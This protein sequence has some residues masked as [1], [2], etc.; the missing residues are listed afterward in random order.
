[1]AGIAYKEELL[2]FGTVETTLMNYSDDLPGLGALDWAQSFYLENSLLLCKV[3]S[4]IIIL[5]QLF[6]CTG[7][8]TT[9]IALSI[10]NS[11]KLQIV[12]P[13]PAVP[14]LCLTCDQDF[15]SLFIAT[16][17]EK[18]FKFTFFQGYGFSSDKH[19]KEMGGYMLDGVFPKCFSLLR[20]GVDDCDV[21]IGLS[22]GGIC[23]VSLPGISNS[24][25]QVPS[26]IVVIG[27][28]TSIL[29]T[30]TQFV[31]KR[32]SQET[33]LRVASMK[34]SLVVSLLSSGVLR[35]YSSLRPEMLSECDLATGELE[36]FKF[37]VLTD[38]HFKVVVVGYKENTTWWICMVRVFP[39]SFEVMGKFTDLGD[40]KG[41][42]ASQQGLWT[43]WDDQGLSKISLTSFNAEATQIYTYENTLQTWDINDNHFQ[44]NFAETQEELLKRIL[45][46]GRFSKDNLRSA[47][48]KSLGIELEIGSFEDTNILK[49]LSTEQISAVF[50]NL[51]SIQHKDSEILDICTCEEIGDFLVVTIRGSNGIGVLRRVTSQIEAASLAI[52]K[53][54][55]DNYALNFSSS[56]ERLNRFRIASEVSGIDKGLSVIRLW[57]QKYD[58]LL[59]TPMPFTMLLKQYSEQQL[60]NHFLQ[61]LQRALPADINLAVSEKLEFLLNNFSVSSERILN[62][63]NTYWPGFLLSLVG[64]S[65]AS[66]VDSLFQYTLDLNL[67]LV[68]LSTFLKNYAFQKVKS[69]E[70]LVS[71]GEKLYALQMALHMPLKNFVKS[72]ANVS[73][74][75]EMYSFPVSIAPVYIMSKSD[76][77]LGDKF[78]FCLGDLTAWLSQ[79]VS[80]AVKIGL[81]LSET[82]ETSVISKVLAE[83]GEGEILNEFFQAENTVS[84]AALYLKAKAYISEGF[85]EIAQRDFLQA[86]AI[87]ETGNF[88]ESYKN[89]IQG[90]WDFEVFE[91][92]NIMNVYSD[93]VSKCIKGK[94][95]KKIILSDFMISSL[96]VEFNEEQIVETVKKLT[97]IRCFH[98]AISL[99][100]SHRNKRIVKQ[101]IE[102]IIEAIGEISEFSMFLDLPLSSFH[103]EIA[104]KKLQS[105]C[106]DEHFDL[107]KTISSAKYFE[108]ATCLFTNLVALEEREA[109]KSNRLSWSHALYSFALNNQF[110]SSA[111]EAMYRYSV[112]I[113]ELLQRLEENKHESFQDLE[114]LREILQEHLMFALLAARNINKNYEECWFLVNTTLHKNKRKTSGSAATGQTTVNRY[115]VSLQELEE[116]F[117]SIFSKSNSS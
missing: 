103:K 67:L 24:E 62:I 68:L 113:Q 83:Y 52:R 40:L 111:A 7:E 23:F 49:D 5:E 29:K 63:S 47:V 96:Y 87:L 16:S 99:I 27:A 13:S 41:L 110:Y 22:S 71:V 25:Y 66:M 3:H 19:L 42:S 95:S 2:Q 78:S 12:L 18:I 14:Q 117:A 75:F 46:P 38:P 64:T 104:L 108:K 86:G 91:Q 33:V 94:N 32:N 106:A 73:E 1:M 100:Q 20:T 81:L 77:I 10:E 35:L 45:K 70:N 59:E 107:I 92:V 53:I 34:N 93:A 37:A 90:P 84:A 60:P 85:E 98:E 31:R 112:E 4:S 115:L 36:T 61:L 82:Q 114:F 102:I 21:C 79:S 50:S 6:F 15:Y 97:E 65:T 89:F 55:I 105:K 39:S 51:K 116:T 54:A 43:V 58:Y 72:H 88:E 101:V 9:E 69:S 17:E 80:A 28:P 11:K 57:R 74:N 76:I 8:D 109:Y 26:K 30:L 56:P 48:C 44:D